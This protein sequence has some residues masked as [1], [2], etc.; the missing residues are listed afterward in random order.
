MATLNLY[1]NYAEQILSLYLWD[2][3]TPPDPSELAD[4]KWIRPYDAT[5]TVEVNA[6]SYMATAGSHLSLANQ[7]MFQPVGWVE[8]QNPTNLR[9]GL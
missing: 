4:D 8:V 7:K 5:S 9:F 6:S 3:I 1:G 2:Q